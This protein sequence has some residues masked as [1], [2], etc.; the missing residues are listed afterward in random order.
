MIKWIGQH[1]VS[2]VARFRSDVYLEDI[3]DGTVAN[4]KFLGLDSDNKI[5][6]EVITPEADITSVE[7][8]DDSGK[9]VQFANGDASFTILG[10]GA[11]GTDINLTSGNFT[12]S[13]DNTSSQASV[14]NSGS[15]VIQDITL[16]TYGHVTGLASKTIGKGDL[17][18]ENVDNVSEAT[19]TTNILATADKAD[20]GLNHVDNTSDADKPVSTATQAALDAKAPTASP[21][22]TGTVSGITASMVGLSNV[23][24][25]SSATIRGEIVDSD[26]PSTIARDSELPTRTSL[27][28]NNVDNTSD[29]NKPISTA[30]QAALDAKAPIANPTFTGAISGSF[31]SKGSSGDVLVNDSGEIKSR[32]VL[33]LRSDLSLNNVENKTSATIR[34]E[35]VSADI[36][37]NAADTSGNAAT[38]TALATARNIAGVAFDGTANIS[39]NNNAITN[40]AG[41]LTSSDLA[42]AGAITRVKFEM[43]DGTVREANGGPADVGIIGGEGVD[44][45]LDSSYSTSQI[46][47]GGAITISVKQMCVTTHNFQLNNT[48]GVKNYVPFNNLNESTAGTM[49]NYWTRTIAPYPGTIKKIA[50]RSQT[51]LGS[52]CTLRISKITDTTDALTSGTHVD[53]TNIDL[54]TAHTTVVETMNTNSFAAGDVVGVALERSA[55]TAAQVVLT[56][57]WEY[58]V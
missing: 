1:I 42:S 14:D 17:N 21:T 19:L 45:S 34:G 54:S 48:T 35:I 51:S 52:S 6:K 36:P 5:V 57:V 40:G 39:L 41:Y 8:V 53:N 7:L 32:T 44:T 28:I 43:D 4:N 30:Q 31:S 2:L 20:V 55:G 22:F 58:T 12:I 25:K 47:A 11:I 56:I 9:Q 46:P 15:T 50:V 26:I 37:N 10:G 3:A 49:A 18:L 27:S 38:A 16:D 33:E 23:E 24:D 13:H 29:A